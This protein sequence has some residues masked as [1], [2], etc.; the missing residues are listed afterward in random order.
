MMDKTKRSIFLGIN[1]IGDNLRLGKG[2][3]VNGP[4]TLPRFISLVISSIA[5]FSKLSND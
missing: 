2:L 5:T 4:A 1:P 3:V